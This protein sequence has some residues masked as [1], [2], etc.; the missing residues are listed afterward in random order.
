MVFLQQQ[1]T[2]RWGYENALLSKQ[3][4]LAKITHFSYLFYP[5]CY[6]VTVLCKFVSV[7]DDT[8]PTKDGSKARLLFDLQLR[9]MNCI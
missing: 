6:K 7:Y 2:F 1:V 3:V 4:S 8:I 5:L 9:M